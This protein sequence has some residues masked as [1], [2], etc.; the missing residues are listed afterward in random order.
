MSERF[1]WW[2][3]SKRQNHFVPFITGGLL[4]E[5]GPARK[6]L[7]PEELYGVSP[8][9]VGR[10]QRRFIVWHSVPK[11]LETPDAVRG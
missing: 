1:S 5:W 7:E 4:E 8:G 9:M 10:R 6:S 3:T 2:P 11:G